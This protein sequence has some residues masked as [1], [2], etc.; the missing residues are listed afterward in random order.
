MPAK[1]FLPDNFRLSSIG[2]HAAVE[3]ILGNF[4]RRRTDLDF[5]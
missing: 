4:C 1:D 5:L 3:A 2:S